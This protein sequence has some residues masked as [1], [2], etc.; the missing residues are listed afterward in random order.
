ML[1]RSITT[2][3]AAAILGLSLAGCEG[4]MEEEGPAERR[5]EQLDESME[6]G[7]QQLEERGEALQE[8]A[9]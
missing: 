5:G 4:A 2:L 7:G 1:L 6:R 8:R 9:Q 3:F